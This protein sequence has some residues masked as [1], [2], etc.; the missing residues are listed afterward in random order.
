MF[1]VAF[2]L[3]LAGLCCLAAVFRL[4]PAT[5]LRAFVLSV[6]LAYGVV[7]LFLLPSFYSG[8]PNDAL[9]AAA[10]RERI[11]R[12]N[13]GVA[14]HEDPTQLHRDLLFQAR[15]VVEESNDLQ[16]LALSP[17]PYLLLASP[18][19]ADLLKATARVREI[20]SYRYLPLRFFTLTGVFAEPAPERLVLLANFDF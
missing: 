3:V 12:P 7:N 19:E 4:R 18:A 2:L 5:A 9:I 1:G 13:L 16:S 11:L 17:R 20:G 10:T 8:Q 6:W 15:L 14:A